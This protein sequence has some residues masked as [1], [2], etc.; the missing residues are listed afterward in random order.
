MIEI[1]PFSALMEK[2]D[3]HKDFFFKY[4]PVT[5]G[6]KVII[7]DDSHTLYY[8]IIMIRIYLF[9]YRYFEKVLRFAL[10]FIIFVL[11]RDIYTQRVTYI[12][13]IYKSYNY[14]NASY[15]LFIHLYL[16]IIS[17]QG[18]HLL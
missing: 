18:V 15:F 8:K 16:L 5:A 17:V 11:H 1:I 4:F 2:V 13:Y 9:V 6:I 3:H 10:H 7:Q 12:S 14:K